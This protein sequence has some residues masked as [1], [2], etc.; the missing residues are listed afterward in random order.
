M[1]ITIKDLSVFPDHHPA[2]GTP[3]ILNR[4]NCTL[5]DGEITLLVGQV[6]AGKST[7]LDVI[8]ALRQPDE[9]TIC[10]NQKPIW[11]GRKLDVKTVR[12]VGM[13]FQSPDEQ[14]FAKTVLAEFKYSLRQLRLSE[15][16]LRRCAESALASVGLSPELLQ[17]A[18]LTLSQGQ[19]RRVALATTFAANP[20]WLLLDEP[21][22]GLDTAASSQFVR[23]LIEKKQTCSGGL[24]IATHDLDTFL[25]V[26]ER[27]L[28][29]K[30]GR[31]VA[32]VTPS[33]LVD[34]HDIW[35]AAEVGLPSAVQLILHSEAKN[36][37]IQLHSYR[38]EAAAAAIRQ[39]I[40][41]SSVSTSSVWRRN[42]EVKSSLQDTVS[43]SAITSSESVGSA[44]GSSS[45]AALPVGSS[46][47]VPSN[48]LSESASSSA[49]LDGFVRRLD[50]RAKW[51][52]YMLL[53]VAI[54]LQSNWDG[55]IA[56]S[57]V[58]LA[59]VLVSRVKIQETLR[60]LAPFTALL[61]VSTAFA[62]V[63]FSQQAPIWSGKIAGFSLLAANT[64]AKSLFPFLLIMI[65]GMLLP[66]TT[67]QLRM[68]QG[69]EQ[70]LEFLKK[71]GLPVEAFALATSLTL[72]FIPVIIGELRR[73]SRIAQ[74]RQFRKRRRQGI[75]L[76]DIPAVAIPLLLSI[77][78]I[79]DQLS[80]ALE[81]RGYHSVGQPRTRSVKLRFTQVDWL[82]IFL[83]LCIS[84]MLMLF[85]FLI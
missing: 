48:S 5:Y 10:F 18:P 42:P 66:A 67:S 59:T 71:L 75:P 52:A 4:L 82:L 13:V 37:P 62:A 3:P 15:V 65:L 20:D 81:A 84:L 43:S 83:F 70:S 69:L 32:D 23:H 53:S 51:L 41:Q 44:S 64:T 25:P 34:N 78:A 2:R 50:P 29:L 27:V 24:V 39:R 49:V 80:T 9:G 8:G 31:I 57:C 22:A 58:T 38:P 63:K 14:L 16:Q 17:A 54:L 28:V 46:L 26:A 55:L 77:L 74:S 85:R 21:T 73:F 40:Q 7:L 30:F 1:P 60:L 36:C 56:A 33:Q 11:K 12:K 6:G 19:K 45:T 35:T 68:K 61:A 79:G 76:C 72:R 47:E